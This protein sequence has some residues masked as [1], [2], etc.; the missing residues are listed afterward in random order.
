MAR[1]YPFFLF[2]L[3]WSW[4]STLSATESPRHVHHHHSHD[5]MSGHWMAP[6]KEARRRN[7]VR[8]DQASLRRGETLY[9]KHCA[10]CH[11]ATG[12]GDGTAGLALD[13]GPANLKDMAPHHSDGDLAWKIAKGRGAMPSWKKTLKTRQIWD[14]VNYLRQLEK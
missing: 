3:A 8:A 13:P 11:G 2:L 12:Q 7:P 14:V 5:A 10:S 4:A 6:A 9:Q 1:I